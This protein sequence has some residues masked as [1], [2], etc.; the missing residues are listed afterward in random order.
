MKIFNRGLQIAGDI[1]SIGG[2]GYSK[3][4]TDG[5]GHI[6]H[7]TGATLPTDGQEGFAVGC[8][9]T[10]S[11]GGAGTTFYVNE[12]T[13]SSCDFNIV[14]G[15]GVETEV[16]TL[17][18]GAADTTKEGACTSGSTI[19]GQY[20]YNVTGTPAPSHCELE[21]SGATLYGTLTAVPGTSNGLGI[22]TVLKLA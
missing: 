16:A 8:I 21:V 3:V 4:T 2:Y 13:A 19:L 6:T 14:S 17:D 22:K 9:F 15:G 18:F 7:L 10:D 1:V 11:D 12:G 20:V 5:S